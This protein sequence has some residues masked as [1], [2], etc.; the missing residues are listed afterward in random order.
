VTPILLDSSVLFPNVLRDTL[1][2]LAEHELFE[3]QWSAAILAE[4][5][6]TVIAKRS[7]TASAIDR[8]LALMSATFDYAMVE[9]WEHLVD[10]LYLPD[11]DDRHVLAAALAGEAQTIVTANLRHFPADDLRPHDIVAISP[12]QFLS[13]I[14][15]TEPDIVI[16]A[17]HSQA[18]RYRR[19]PMELN[20]LLDCLDRAGAPIFARRIRKERCS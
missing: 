6:R 16:E 11:P 4:V 13:K 5:R 12:D 9:G 10:Q 15:D 8:T 17:L 3:P 7:V 2:T 20:D 18:E 1:L 14:L 19:P